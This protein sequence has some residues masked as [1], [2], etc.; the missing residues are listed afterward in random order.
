MPLSTLDSYGTFLG[1]G[2]SEEVSDITVDHAGNTY[3]VGWT[4]SSDF[5]SVPGVTSFRG[6]SDAFVVKLDPSGTIVYATILGGSGD[7]D[8]ASGVAVTARG[9]ACV[10][11]ETSS[12][13]FPVRRAFQPTLMGSMNAFV[14]VLT[15]SGTGLVYSTYLGGQGEDAGTGIAVDGLGYAYVTGIAKSTSF[16]TTA[17]VLSRGPV[18]FMDTFVAKFTPEGSLKFSTLLGGVNC[19]GL[20]IALGGAGIAGGLADVFVTGRSPR[21]IP[22]VPVPSPY[23]GGIQE[24]FVVRLNRS[25]S[26]LLYL[27]YLGGSSFDQGSGI[28]VDR[29]DN[30]YVTG[31]TESAD[32]FTTDG[33]IF[34]AGASSAGWPVHH[35]FVV[36]LDAGG[37]VRYSMLLQGVDDDWGRDIAVNNA[38]LAYITGG[39][40]SSD[41]PITPD[42][43]SS[44]FFYESV[45]LSVVDDAGRL[46]YSTFF[47]DGQGDGIAVDETANVY[48][49][50][51]TS[52]LGFPIGGP[53]FAG[54]PVDVFVTRVRW[55]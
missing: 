55:V 20:A 37:T 51:I 3:V 40:Y 32:F 53:R 6:S 25:G 19:E 29:G 7:H 35:A 54:G 11:G 44:R 34:R 15:E 47:G 33:S 24:A 16:P 13:D 41:F 49:A 42:A 9:F 4:W 22:G 30:A 46:I 2:R 23:V 45:F 8:S 27:A 5:P 17:G 43:L 18:S 52:A 1:G 21:T 38:G 39:T 36:K 10:T 31:H 26:A 14:T 48:L 12:R 28:A 50:G